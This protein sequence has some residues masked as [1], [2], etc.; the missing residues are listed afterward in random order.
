MLAIG[1]DY[2]EKEALA[3]FERAAQ[4]G[5]APAEVNLAIMYINGWGTPVNYGAAQHWLRGAA[6]QHFARAYYNLGILYLEG[7][8][9]KHDN[10][11]AFRWF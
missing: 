9:V 8:G 7:K 4:H 5:Y 6:E 3:W 11:E 1:P 10:G 2:S